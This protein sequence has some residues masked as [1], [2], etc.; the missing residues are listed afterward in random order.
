MPE[1]LQF[2]SIFSHERLGEISIWGH[3]FSFLLLAKCYVNIE[4]N[5]GICRLYSRIEGNQCQNE[6]ERDDNILVTSSSDHSIRQWSK[7]LEKSVC[8]RFYQ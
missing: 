8:A 7:V 1:I 5:G 3:A 4:R 2:D 6:T